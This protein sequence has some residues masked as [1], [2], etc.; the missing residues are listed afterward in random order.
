[1]DSH[2]IQELPLIN[3]NKNQN[4]E[5]SFIVLI[6]WAEIDEYKVR[7]KTVLFSSHKLLDSNLMVI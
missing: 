5:G 7:K 1:M 4:F 3:E 6:Y 2:V